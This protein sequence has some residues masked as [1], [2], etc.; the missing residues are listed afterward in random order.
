VGVKLN[1]PNGKLYEAGGGT[2]L[3]TCTVLN[4][5]IISCTGLTY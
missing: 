4:D 1:N 3:G 2:Q 5:Q